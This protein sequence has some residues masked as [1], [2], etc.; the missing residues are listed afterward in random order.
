VLGVPESDIPEIQNRMRE[1]QR[2]APLSGTA[3]MDNENLGFKATVHLISR[4][5]FDANEDDAELAGTVYRISETADG[6]TGLFEVE[7]LLRNEDHRLRPG[8]IARADLVVKH[9]EGWS[10]PASSVIAPNKSEGQQARGPLEEFVFTFEPEPV[11]EA[12]G[13]PAESSLGRARRVDLVQWVEQREDVVVTKTKA[14][15]PIDRLIWRGQHRLM[16]GQ[17]VKRIPFAQPSG[18]E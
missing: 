5:R 13:N 9:V 12:S 6:R 17:L 3:A 4:N 7:V 11:A 2:D 15:V 18:E 10:I 1:V 8:M 14:S 16:D